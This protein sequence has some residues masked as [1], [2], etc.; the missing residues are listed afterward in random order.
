M[1]ECLRTINKLASVSAREK[2]VR[3]ID[4]VWELPRVYLDLLKSGSIRNPV[5]LTLAIMVEKKM[6]T[7]PSSY[8]NVIKPHVKRLKTKYP[9]LRACHP[10]VEHLLDAPT[11]HPEKFSGIDLWQQL[12]SFEF[13][14]SEDELKVGHATSHPRIAIRV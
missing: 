14:L 9:Y 12:E 8:R 2:Y 7:D 5:D 6:I 4:Q 13:D 11:R 3:A 10:L 1:S